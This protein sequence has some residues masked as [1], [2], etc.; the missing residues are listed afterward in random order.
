MSSQHVTISIDSLILGEPLPGT[1]YVKIESRFVA[2]RGAGDI[3]DSSLYDRLQFKKVQNLYVLEEDYQKFLA[4]GG[5]TET[6]EGPPGSQENSEFLSAWK[7]TRRKVFDIFQ[8]DQPHANIHEA[9]S[10]SKKLV[11]QVLRFPYAVQSLTQLQAFSKGTVDHSMNVSVLAVYLAMQMGYTHNL[12]LQ[13]VGVGGL[14]HDIGKRKIEIQDSDPE[15]VVDAKMREHA[16]MGMRMLETLPNV[17]DEVKWIVAQHHEFHDGTGYPKKLR[18]NNIYDLA[19]IVMIANEFD[20]LVAQAKGPD[21]R[22]R[23]KSALKIFDERYFHR[24]DPDKHE[25]AIRILK[26]GI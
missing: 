26:L 22:E 20:H 17:P 9:L 10:A 12:I 2:F 6:P 23:Q 3:I 21:L 13:H 7:D 24:V 25:K 18:G 1:L 5:S 14:L 11:A 16:T 19:R 8:T 4:W 15:S